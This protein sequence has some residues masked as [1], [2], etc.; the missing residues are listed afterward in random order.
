MLT[1]VAVGICSGLFGIGGGTI[2]VPVMF[3]L[4]DQGIVPAPVA[5]EDIAALVIFTALASIVITT[6]ATSYFKWKLGSV[7]FGEVKQLSLGFVPGSIL[8]ALLLVSLEAEIIKI[9]IAFFFML[10]AFTFAQKKNR[11]KRLTSALAKIPLAIMGLVVSVFSVILG[12]G[13]SVFNVGILKNHGLTM[14]QATG[15]SAACGVIISLVSVLTG[16][17]IA[18]TEG[19]NPLVYIHLPFLVSISA[20]SVLFSKLG[21]RLAHSMDEY[22]LKLAFAIYL[23]LVSCYFI[24][25]V[26][27]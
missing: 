17:I 7:N 18:M 11:F 24:F 19:N 1:G 3:I 14:H 4:F 20:V 13:G 8:G 12:I 22:S 6:T 15:T 10:F 26:L 27:S 2:V 25:D 23:F 16:G 21:V 9:V 5:E